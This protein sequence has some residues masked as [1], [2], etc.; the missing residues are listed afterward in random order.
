MRILI[1]GGAGFVGS[2]LALLFKRDNPALEIIALDNLK[3]RGSEL[4]LLRLRTGGVQFIHGDVRNM[5]DLKAI[6]PVDILIECSAEP[7]VQAGYS[8]DPGYLINT[9]LIGAINCLEHLRL[10]GGSLI[11]LSSSRVYPIASLRALPLTAVGDRFIIAE[12]QAGE[13]WSQK[14][15]SEAFPLAGT[16]SLYGSTKL[17]AELL[18][19][20]YAAMYGLKSIV[21]RCGVIT[22]PWQM[23]RVDQGFVS[24]WVAAHLYGFGLDYMGYDGTGK[25]VRDILH[26]DD[27]YELLVMQMKSLG[28]DGFQ[29]WNVG[30]GLECSVSLAELTQICR[31]ATGKHIAIG[32]NLTTHESDIPYYVSDNTGVSGVTG[33]TPKRRPDRDC[34]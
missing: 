2:S 18:I 7:S 15:I 9:N 34:R 21:N 26:I 23:G 1:T 19:C 5:E 28:N 11:F 6:G 14:G 33:W 22:G 30:G 8:E 10:S 27:L 25:Q 3:R 16:R 29:V 24:R 17:C 20:E 31:D 4:N 13:G 12:G 32:K